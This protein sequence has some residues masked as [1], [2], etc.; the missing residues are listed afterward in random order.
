MIA[1]SEVGVRYARHARG[2]PRLADVYLPA[3]RHERSVV[4][5][6][7]GG[8]VIGSR[9]M[10]PVRFLASRL[11]AEGLAVCAIDYR[12]MFRGGRLADATSD[13][14]EAIGWWSDRTTALGLDPR[15]ITLIGLSAGASLSMLAASRAPTVRALACCF[16][17]YEL[18]ALPGVVARLLVG[19]GD[20]EVW[21][22]RSPVAIEQP[23]VPT[24]LLHGSADRLV[25]ARQ[26]ERLA[27]HR[28]SLG[29]P[30]RLVI[31]EGARHGFFR[32]PGPAAEAGVRE[33]TA[34][35]LA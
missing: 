33:L 15:G 24:L 8:W 20:R 19:S 30:T 17:V 32:V 7:G 11:A 14:V 6:H 34:H 23:A 2:T 18:D 5:V 1:P 9:T 4:I 21:R 16:G 10:K 22:A 27:A 28:T 26:S 3:T 25:S 12:L 29:L 13:V 31:Y 35:A